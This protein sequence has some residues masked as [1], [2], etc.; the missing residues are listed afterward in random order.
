MSRSKETFSKKDVRNKQ[1]K[2]R[3]EKEQRRLEK[4]EQGKRNF[5]DMIAWVDENGVISSTPP[6]STKKKE[7]K[8]ARL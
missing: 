7:I 6:D 2:K 1:A 3:K 8:N 5:D 4:K